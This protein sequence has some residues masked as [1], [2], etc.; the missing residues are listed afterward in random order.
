MSGGFAFLLYTVILVAIAILFRPSNMSSRYAYAAVG[1]MDDEDEDMM[2]MA[3]PN[4]GGKG[5]R[6]DSDEEES[7]VRV[8]TG[9]AV[10]KAMDQ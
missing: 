6:E 2:E 9:G 3:S 5:Q 10:G 8:G 7:G 4:N 1:M